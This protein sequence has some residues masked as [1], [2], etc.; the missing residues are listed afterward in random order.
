MMSDGDM[1]QFSLSSPAS[2]DAIAALIRRLAD[3]EA[4]L[5]QAV[6]G[7]D[8]VID[9]DRGSPFLLSEAQHALRRSEGRYN[10]LMA[11]IAAVVLELDPNG[12]IEFV[13]DA[14]SAVTG[15]QPD[16]LLGQQW[17][18]VLFPG[19]YRQQ[20]DTLVER[21]AGGD[22]TGFE[23][24]L[25]AKDGHL[26]ALEFNSANQYHADGTL[27]KI[28]GLGIDITQR[29][30]AERE[31]ARYH[32]EL[33]NLVSERTA[34]L[35]T[36]N[37]ALS[38]SEAAEREQRVLAETLHEIALKMIGV[39][40]LPEMLDT[41]LSGVGSVVACETMDL[42]LIQA[43]GMAHFAGSRG[44]R[45]H[46]FEPPQQTVPFAWR[47]HPLLRQMGETR[48]PVILSDV[49]FRRDLPYFT[50]A[51]GRVPRPVFLSFCRMKASVLSF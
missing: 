50:P 46:G 44:Y 3:A 27:D 14:A 33:E 7:V 30:L 36:A 20:V 5:K 43:S 23:L 8:A 49:R 24:T 9:P 16:E 42:V 4:A 29:K 39:H 45:E 37:E 17:H 11:R 31:L 13:N 2:T 26:V 28:V 41:I 47:E 19:K 18:D 6:T 51:S 40:E 38:K 25:V 12:T 22:V 10:Q 35:Q 48:Q 15:Y 21:F 34:Q 1:Q 32:A